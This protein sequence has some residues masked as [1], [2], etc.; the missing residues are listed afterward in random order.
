M[1][2]QEPV[3]PALLYAL[4]SMTF[5]MAAQNKTLIAGLLNELNLTH[6][7][8]N[9]LWLMDPEIPAPNM[10]EL[11]DRLHCDRSTITFIADRL[12]EFELINRTVDPANRRVKTLVLTAK[13]RR[14]RQRLVAEMSTKT[15]LAKL[16]EE[17]RHQLHALF[18]KASLRASPS[19]PLTIEQEA[20]PLLDR[21]VR[22]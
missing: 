22:K 3:N 18:T 12:E 7:L 16:S 5:D 1:K 19:Y 14:V 9:A 2:K 11:A 13:G 17:E 15:P 8:A 4:I 6:S 21:V 20:R 10:S